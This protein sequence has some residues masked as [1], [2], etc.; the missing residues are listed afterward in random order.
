[1]TA[2][3]GLLMMVG[4]VAWRVA[5]GVLSSRISPAFEVRAKVEAKKGPSGLRIKGM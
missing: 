4:A 2:V 3:V 5:Q 1:M